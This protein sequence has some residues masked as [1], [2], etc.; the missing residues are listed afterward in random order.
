MR[1]FVTG[2]DTGVGKTVVVAMLAQGLEADYWKPIQTGIEEGSDTNWVQ[3]HT[4]L[5][6]CRCHPERYRLKLPVSPHLAAQA[7]GVAI[8]LQDFILPS[9]DKLI[10]EGCGGIL[11]P[12][13]HRGDLLIDLMALWNLPTVIVSRST[14]GTINHTLLTIAMLR[15]RAIPILGVILNGPYN[16]D[17]RCA[18]AH[19]GKIP[20]LGE[21]PLQSHIDSDI[22]QNLF[23][24]LA[25]PCDI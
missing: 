21:I 24:S 5:P 9:V 25:W 1:I 13:N 20:I 6:A 19:F 8:Q 10:V 7:A 23:A 2:T 3:A 14:L 15:Q 11:V 22:L 17:N 18:I 16:A 12:I 4:T